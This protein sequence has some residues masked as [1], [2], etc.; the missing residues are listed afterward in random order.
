MKKIIIIEYVHYQYALTLSEFFKN[1]EIIYIFSSSI[2]KS[3]RRFNPNFNSKNIWIYEPNRLK[4]DL[5][6]LINR[7]NIE[8]PDLL[9]IDPI[10][11]NFKEFAQI[12]K[13]VNSK[14]L[15]TTHNINTWFKPSLRS[16]KDLKE[17]KYKAQILKNVDYIAVEDF[18]YNHLKNNEKTLFK[19]YNFVYIPY[20]I[21]YGKVNKIKKN[22]ER[23]KIVLPGSIDKERRKY[24]DTIKVIRKLINEDNNKFIFSFAG[25][26]IGEYGNDILN[27]LE[28]IKEI[29]NNIVIF[30][31]EKPSPE[32]FRYEMESADIVLST[33]TKYFYTLGTKEEI[34]KTKPTAA[35]HDMV[36][37]VLPGILPKHLNI[38]KELKSSSLQY[39]TADDLY[40]NIISLLND[41]KLE[42]LSNEA[43]KNSLK[44]TPKEI[45]KR[46]V[47]KF[48]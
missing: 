9:C 24:E 26:A 2:N 43:K 31:K 5:N 47:I 3:I 40:N 18:I 33:S 28:K 22:D 7:I 15:F 11:D 44:Y 25:P 12:C 37:F 46:N 39:Q 38:P 34:G 13:S 14:I 41:N 6:N 36:S 42:E 23:I 45:L 17:K 10:F 27:E 30:F 1:D 16:L 21:Y 32:E 20:T 29:D 35:I 8:N 19:K 4:I 48:L